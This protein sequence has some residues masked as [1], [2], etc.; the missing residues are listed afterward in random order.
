[1]EK[2]ESIKKGIE[3]ADSGDKTLH[4]DWTKGPILK[5]LLLLS[6]PMVVMESLYVISQFYDMIWVGRIGAASVAGV[7][8]AS[9]VLI[10]VM[11]IDYGLII[12][13]RAMIARHVGSRDM[14]GAG[15]VAG[16][17]FLLAAI[18]GGVMT[19]IGYFVSEPI[20][21]LFGAQSDVVREGTKYLWLMFAGWVPLE[22]LVMGLYVIQATGD[23]MR[24]MTIEFLIRV[25]HVVVCPLLVMGYWGFPRMGVE[26]AAIANV[27]SQVLG[28]I[29][30]LWLLLAGRTRLRLTLGD[31]R[32][33]PH[34]MVRILKIGLPAVAM[35]LQRS[36]GTI[37]LA[38]LIVPFGTLAVA[39]H[40]LVAKID[41][42]LF[43]PSVGLGSGA[44]V[45]VGQN[46][47]AHQPR[48]AEK[49]AWL[50]VGFVELF[51]LLSSLVIVLWPA[52]IMTIFTPD[53]ELI[54]VGVVFLRIAAIS[55]ILLAPA[56]VFQSCIAGAGDTLPNMIISIG[57]IW[58]VQI[59]LAIFL[60]RFNGLGVLGVRWAIVASALAGAIGYLVYFSLGRWKNKRI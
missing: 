37:F 60:P 21:G 56:A 39:A 16:Q 40:S 28:A 52:E 1:M 17:A 33:S 51:L 50:A 22:I 48:R 5:N 30:G 31:F 11:S 14:A 55:Y 26:G 9:I 4:K 53:R 25:F 58:A 23:T 7:G 8:I 13:V 43:M 36:F 29:M 34:T 54:N 20:M 46:L 27:A 24:P 49:G 15:Y 10:F 42:C 35:Q 6:W 38:W 32:M 47:G 2:L 44:A 57:V 41:M 19:V 12:G 59:P 45:L 18:W 3:D